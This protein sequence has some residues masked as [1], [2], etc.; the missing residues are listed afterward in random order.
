MKK[1]NQKTKSTP[2]RNLRYSDV[3]PDLGDD[4]I[5]EPTDEQLLADYQQREETNA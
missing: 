1:E 5:N 4:F 2:S 3:I